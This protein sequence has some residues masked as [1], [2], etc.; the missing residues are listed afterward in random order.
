MTISLIIQFKKSTS[1]CLHSPCNNIKS[2]IQDITRDIPKPVSSF[3]FS[4][5]QLYDYLKSVHLAA[6][7]KLLKKLPSMLNQHIKHKKRFLIFDK[8]TIFIQ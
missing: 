8:G 7:G 2:D 5:T 3:Y 1:V 6:S 4:C